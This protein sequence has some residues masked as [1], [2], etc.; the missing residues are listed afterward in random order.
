M[1]ED[2][3]IDFGK[4]N[5]KN[6]EQFKTKIKDQIKELEEKLGDT[7]AN[8]FEKVI[9]GA[10]DKVQSLFAILANLEHG[11]YSLLTGNEMEKGRKSPFRS[12]V[13]NHVGL[14]EDE[15]GNF[16]TNNEKD[17]KTSL[18]LKKQQEKNLNDA[19][20]DNL[21]KSIED[22]KKRKKHN[23]TQMSVTNAIRKGDKEAN[24]NT[25]KFNQKEEVKDLKA[26]DAVKEALY[27]Q[28]T[29]KMKRDLWDSKWAKEQNKYKTAQ[30][31]A[32]ILARN[33]Y[34][35]YAN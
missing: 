15:N 2:W 18:A 19:H 7:T 3:S 10:N 34:P 17:M 11:A 8:A 23:R 20:P 32:D 12:F 14:H 9:I 30:R 26:A 13:A 6:A 4:I 16:L 22:N 27:D 35:A 31:I 1:N 29:H 24:R 25:Y 33:G 28:E 5:I 21:E